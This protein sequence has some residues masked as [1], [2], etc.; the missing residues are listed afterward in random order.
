MQSSGMPEL[1]CENDIVYMCERMSL[2]FD[3]YQAAEN[4]KE[5]IHDSHGDFYRPIDDAFHIV[6][7]K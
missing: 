1:T 2:E 3:Q 4:F 6:K 5:E 7:N